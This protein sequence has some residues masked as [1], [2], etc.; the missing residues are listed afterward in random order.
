MV[1]RLYSPLTASKPSPIAISGTRMLSNDTNDGSGSPGGREQPQEQERI[2]RRGVADLLGGE[3]D[4][5]QREQHHQP[6]Q[7]QHAHAGQMVEQ[8][9]EEHDAQ[10]A[11]GQSLHAACRVLPSASCSGNSGCRSRRGSAPRPRAAA[12]GRRRRPRRRRPPAHVALGNRCAAV[13]DRSAR[14]HFTPGISARACRRGPRRRPRPRRCSRRPAPGGQFGT[15]PSSAMLPCVEQRDAVADALHALEQMRRQ[16]HADA[17]V[18]ERADDLQQLE[19][20]PADRGRRSARRGSRSARPSSGFRQGRAAGAC[21]ARRC[22][23]A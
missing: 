18:L 7:H 14:P 20:S 4:R 16:Q 19:R 10:A 8:L 22:R 12:A 13:A 21:R 15:V 9:A 5:R 2:L 17:V 1:R 3:I 11:P 6:F 23:R